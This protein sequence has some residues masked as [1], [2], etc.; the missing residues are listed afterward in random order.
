MDNRREELRAKRSRKKESSVQQPKLVLD[1]KTVAAL[2]DVHT[3]VVGRADLKGP[4]QVRFA[5][6]FIAR[7]DQLRPTQTHVGASINSVEPAIIVCTGVPQRL[8]RNAAWAIAKRSVCFQGLVINGVT[9]N[10]RGTLREG[11][12]TRKESRF[13]PEVR[14][15][16]RG[17]ESGP[18]KIEL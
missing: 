5:F 13:A 17:D 18:V 12:D 16:G 14:I 2:G 15:V 11:H 8:E 4:I 10:L 6:E 9:E 7:I 3:G 1:E